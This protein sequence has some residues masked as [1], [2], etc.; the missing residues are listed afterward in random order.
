MQIARANEALVRRRV[1]L[2]WAVCQILVTWFPEHVEL[3]LIYSVLHPIK[4]HVHGSRALLA[5]SAI[6]NSSGDGVVG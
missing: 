1:V 2:C 3:F 6:S 4:S 5:H